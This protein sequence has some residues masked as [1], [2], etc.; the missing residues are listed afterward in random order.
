MRK[1]LLR[2]AAQTAVQGILEAGEPWHVILRNHRLRD[3]AGRLV[4]AKRQAGGQMSP[5]NDWHAGP[6]LASPHLSWV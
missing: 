6:A 3:V 5:H 1:L 2:A 4:E